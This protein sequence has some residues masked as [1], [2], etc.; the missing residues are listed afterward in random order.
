[1]AAR[2]QGEFAEAQGVGLQG[3]AQETGAMV[4]HGSGSGRGIAM[5]AT[6]V[7]KP[8]RRPLRGWRRRRMAGGGA[9]TFRPMRIVSFNANGIRSAASKGFFDWFRAQDADILCVQET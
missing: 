2:L 7:A 1:G 5:I 6:R 3:Q 9:L 4:G 8:R